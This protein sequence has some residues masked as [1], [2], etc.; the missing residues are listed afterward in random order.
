MLKEKIN[1]NT[2]SCLLVRSQDGVLPH[3]MESEENKRSGCKIFTNFFKS[4]FNS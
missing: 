3:F 1:G 2:A 4:R